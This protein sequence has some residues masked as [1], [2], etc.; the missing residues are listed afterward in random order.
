MNRRTFQ[1][2]GLSAV[3]I[4]HAAA[5]LSAQDFYSVTN[6]SSSGEGSLPYAVTQANASVGT[7][8]IYINPDVGT[9][10]LG[11]Q[12][13]VNANVSIVGNGNTI[14]M[15][16]ADR[17]FFIAGGAVSISNLTIQNG[18]ATGGAG[19]DGGGGGAGLGGAIL[20]ANGQGLPS[21]GVSLA[22]AV[23][24][25]NVS[26]LSNSAT[27]G[28]GATYTVNGL[29]GGGGMGGNGG[30]G[31]DGDLG[32]VSGGGGGGFGNGTYGGAGSED[33]NPGAN[34]AFL[35]SS[36][37]AGSGG[38]G[39]AAGGVQGGGGGGGNDG[40][41]DPGGGGGGGVGGASPTSGIRGGDG[42]FGGGGGSAGA[43]DDDDGLG[44]SGG[45]GGGGGSGETGGTGGFGGGGGAGSSWDADPDSNTAGPG[46]FAGGNGFD[47]YLPSDPTSDPP[48]AGGGGAGLGGAI[49][50]M[51]GATVTIIQ[52]ASGGSASFASN[53]VSGGQPGTSNAIAGSAYG[54]D[55]FVGGNVVFSPAS[56]QSLTVANLG[57]AGNL[58]DPNVAA[59][60]SA[61]N[62]NGA[63]F[64]AGEGVVTLTGTNYHSGTITVNSGTL[65]LGA[66]A[67]EQGA[68]L[69][70]V[71]QNAG[72]NATL[73][74]GKNSFLA[75]G[76]WNF[77]TPSAS[78][79]QPVMIAQDAGSEG[80]IVIGN[81]AGSSGAAIAAR[82]FNGGSGTATVEFTQ[83]Y[84]VNSTSDEVY[85]FYTTLTG[86]LGVVQSGIGTTLLQPQ[87]G[88]NTFSG[89]VTVN[90][91]TLA[92][93]STTA[94]LAGTTLVTVNTGG[95]F[96]PGQNDGINDAAVLDLAGGV[97]APST[98]ITESLGVLN[99][100]SS[101]LF[102]LVGGNIT[103]TFSFMS[104][105]APLSIWNYSADLDTISIISGEVVGSLSQISF[106]SDSGQT[107]LGP[108]TL[109]GTLIVPVP[110][111]NFFAVTG[112]AL[113]LI[114]ALRR[115]KRL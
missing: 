62:A 26:F 53:A 17:A 42:G 21:S 40:L 108:G 22:T 45:F 115:T 73:V 14:D 97:F 79:D 103:L 106:Y 55:I 96:A 2:L 44:G 74:L 92:T 95:I 67:T 52:D 89:S 4:V 64:V 39:G 107:Y 93:T 105:S 8:T 75:L 112:V 80:S 15:N 56:G 1:H 83:Q 114:A 91:G 63:L 76:G 66:G 60:A 51:D 110:E 71:G 18:N 41:V 16:R 84:K 82:V 72:D 104:I 46:G 24:L 20:V 101:S 47:G 43:N 38:Y 49:F 98:S 100:T 57:G 9:I 59:H 13:F 48:P 68:S 30:V 61:P 19:A 6:N 81:G 29:G 90:A 28:T 78:T 36:A 109:N 86:S 32:W 37:S 54:P 7:S 31:Y 87:Y 10:S 77:E 34:G 25:T 69:V 23:T 27:G 50:V 94:A 35:S 65:A 12:M 33:G 88:A 5:T 113:L 11:S 85:P 111:A 102:D 58:A 70:T 3:L 99:V